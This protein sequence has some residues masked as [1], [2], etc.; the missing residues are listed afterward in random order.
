MLPLG[1]GV[2]RLGLPGGAAGAGSLAGCGHG[3]RVASLGDFA[4][5]E[6]FS[7]VLHWL[8]VPHGVI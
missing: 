7:V 3:H 8:L 5:A 2:L 6:I 1:A 4:D